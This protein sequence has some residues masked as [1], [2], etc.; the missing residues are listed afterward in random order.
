MKSNHQIPDLCIDIH[1]LMSR[2]NELGRIGA[3]EGGGVCRLALTDDD[4]KGRD[5]VMG[6]MYTL[7]LEVS[8]DRIGNVVGLR[9]GSED[10]NPVTIGSHI[11]TVATGGL[12]D[13]NL[14]V[15]AG[16]EIISG[17]EG[18]QRQV[19][20]RYG[21]DIDLR[22]GINTGRVVVGAVGSDLRL[23]YTAL[24]DAINVAARMEQTAVPGTVHPL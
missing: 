11:D 15:L 24:G 13:G 20:Q 18:Y 10:G 4:R 19:Y 1:R 5:L 8:V 17:A 14:G 22:V 6:W 2:I 12:Y 23:E 3:L 9:R 7:G 16:L 21:I